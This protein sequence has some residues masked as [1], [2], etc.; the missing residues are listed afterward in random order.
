MIEI[1]PSAAAEVPAQ[2]ALWKTCFGDGG[3]FIDLFYE[4]CCAPEDVL[5]LL[6][7][8]ALRSMAAILPMD[9]HFPDG[10][11]GRAGY[12]YALCTH[13][14]S[15]RRGLVRELLHYVDFYLKKHGKDCA[16]LVPAEAGLH[17]FF[18]ALGFEELFSHRKAE[19]AHTCLLPPGGNEAARP[20][21][22]DEY[23]L[24]RER[25]L[26]G[27]FHISYHH[28][29]LAFQ[30]DFSR[31]FGGDLYR[32]TAGGAEC[33]AA[34]ERL[35]PDRVLVKELLAPPERIPQAV[36]ALARAIPAAHYH[37]RT[38]PFPEEGL[39]GSCEQPFGM[40]K[41]YDPRLGRI[42]SRERRGYLGFGFD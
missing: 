2:K 4:R 22:P 3:P 39:P 13:P 8:G 25:Y 9:L 5:V 29:L 36:A 42:W 33:C 15:R 10:T 37:L 23:G 35:G 41:W 31:M 26:N 18:G 34:A 20:A 28:T 19:I 11:E 40:V 1:R 6:E 30:R 24:I 14:D 38:P 12:V 7:D 32:L 17:R 16:I 21:E 27:R